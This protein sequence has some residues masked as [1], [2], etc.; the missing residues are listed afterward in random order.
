MNLDVAL[1]LRLVDRLSG[2]IRK[3]TDATRDLGAAA[4]AGTAAMQRFGQDGTALRHF[5]ALDTG[6]I[7]ASR[8]IE[9]TGPTATRT[10]DRIGALGGDIDHF[11]KLKVQT[12]ESGKA[13]QAAT[14]K[15][16]G[17][18]RDMRDVWSNGVMTPE[19]AKLARTLQRDFGKARV[20]AGRLK[21]TYTDQRLELDRSRRSLRDA[22][23]STSDLADETRRLV[24]ETE[25]HARSIERRD[26]REAQSR[27][28]QN[29]VGRIDRG[30]E[31]N[32]ARRDRMRGQALET[33][34]LAY[35]AFHFMQGAGRTQSELVD[36]G[37]TSDVDAERV[38]VFRRVAERVMNETT[39]PVRD[40]LASQNVL[41]TAGLDFDTAEE[42]IPTIARTATA[43]N[44]LMTDVSR[45]AFSMM[46]GLGLAP[47]ELGRGFDM[48]AMGGKEG[49]FE[50]DNM[51]TYFPSLV[52][53]LKPLGVTGEEGVAT[54]GAGLQIAMKG[55]SDPATAANNFQ[56]FLT[57]LTSP[58]TLKRFGDAGVDLKDVFNEAIASGEN[59]VERIIRVTEGMTGG[60]PF[61]MGEL[62]G[63]M[64]VLAF[65][66]PMLDNMEEYNRIK[67]KMLEADGTVAADMARRMAEDPTLGW[68]RFG[69]GL[70]VIRDDVARPLLPVL[71][72]VTAEITPVAAAVG[73]WVAENGDLVATIGTLL[74]GLFVLKIAVLAI[75]F[76]LSGI[77]GPIM[78]AWKGFTLLR[79]G[80]LGLGFTGG[81]LAG[82]LG[83]IGEAFG[84]LRLMRVFRLASLVA[85]LR[86]GLRLLPPVPWSRLKAFRLASLL[87]PLIWFRTLL[88]AVPWGR[89]RSFRLGSLV[90]P[91]AW[92]ARLLPVIPWSRLKSFRLASLLR[93]LIWFRTLLPA[94]PWG[95]LRSF[96]LGSLV[97]PL[98]WVARLLP[99]VPW[100]LLATR[101]GTFGMNANGWGRL[102]K[103]LQWFGKGALRLIPVIGW[104]V[105]AAD[106]G[107]FAWNM[108][109]LTPLD[110]RGWIDGIDWSFWFSFEWLDLLP[111]W[112]WSDIVPS[113]QSWWAGQDTDITA[114]V[115]YD[116]AF[117]NLGGAVEIRHRNGT[118]EII[119]PGTPLPAV[120]APVD[121]GNKDSVDRYFARRG[122]VAVDGA[123]ERG[124]PVWRGGSFIVGER[125][126]ELFTPGANGMITPH[127]PTQALLRA[128]PLSFDTRPALAARG[129]ATGSG[130]TSVT[131]AAGAIVIQQLPGQDA[132]D[133][134]ERVIDEME[135]RFRDGR[136]SSRDLHD[137]RGTFS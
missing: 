131:L 65:I 107:V 68:R 88:P 8:A 117:D 123:R 104:A 69:E 25:A 22:G 58:E 71:A 79:I 89:L 13:F 26:R 78:T 2:P 73:E 109:G 81:R 41:V 28:L 53:T 44:A 110:W 118:S 51:A 55:T 33:G 113:F 111:D 114:K 9:R 64:Q 122:K 3:P 94:V 74:A 23:V 66:R 86:W 18:S 101:S 56:N 115:R 47:Q 59:P 119:K 132:T 75:G 35:G 67:E 97:K 45:T 27:R 48:L 120:S 34:A 77:A 84:R 12:T 14:N 96:R 92:S 11:R 100:S 36:I 16:A 82:V 93:P 135:R 60:D 129:G 31:N 63:D 103:P 91:L 87:R 5:D 32:H 42:A 124:G 99:A 137:G 98:A 134:A 43:A 39:Q 7:R 130:G 4:T 136:N 102:I 57:K 29:R 133:L 127:G 30:I 20:E 108:L 76:L 54:L 80:M 125:G 50:L 116:G 62:F 21:T 112:S 128:T 17:L 95:R 46:D 106:I 121:L 83:R 10:A 24:R 61:K 37:I 52:P 15:M 72:Q 105:M 40:I 49:K 38:E 70:K 90:R 126:P 6:A 19:Q 85:P 1:V